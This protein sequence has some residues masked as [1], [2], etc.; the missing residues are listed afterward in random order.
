MASR[1]CTQQS[2]R[3][4]LEGFHR[5]IPQVHQQGHQQLLF[6]STA[7]SP[8]LRLMHPMAV[9]SRSKYHKRVRK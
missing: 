2:V 7:S 9:D 6:F 8:S 3:E 5:K 4:E 1:I